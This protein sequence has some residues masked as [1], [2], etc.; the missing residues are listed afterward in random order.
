[1]LLQ[2][3]VLQVGKSLKYNLLTEVSDLCGLEVFLARS[4]TKEQEL[5]L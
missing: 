1:M 5:T 2:I 3:P 4:S